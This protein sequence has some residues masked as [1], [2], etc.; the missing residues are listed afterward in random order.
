MHLFDLG[1][2]VWQVMRVSCRGVYTACGLRWTRAVARVRNM[3]C[4]P[5]AQ[6]HVPWDHSIFAQFP[7]WVGLLGSICVLLGPSSSQPLCPPKFPSIANLHESDAYIQLFDPLSVPPGCLCFWCSSTFLT[8]L[9]LYGNST[10]FQSHSS[11][12][13]W[14]AT[15]DPAFSRV[16]SPSMILPSP[17]SPMKIV[18]GISWK[19]GRSA[20]TLCTLF[21]PPHTRSIVCSLQ[22]PQQI[23]GEPQ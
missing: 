2:R 19:D 4:F 18:V 16:G 21:P 23:G 14:L 20:H 12:T 17:V 13:Q 6:F 1:R 15:D 10:I 22:L 7:L 8:R 9:A 5:V 3:G 11:C